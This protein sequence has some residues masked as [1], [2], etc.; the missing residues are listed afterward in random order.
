MWKWT[1]AAVWIATSNP[2]WTF[3][4]MDANFLPKIWAFMV[5]IQRHSCWRRLDLRKVGLGRVA[6]MLWEA[7]RCDPW[8]GLCNP[9]FPS[10]YSLSPGHRVSYP[11]LDIARVM[12]KE[13]SL[14]SPSFIQVFTMTSKGNATPFTNIQNWHFLINGNTL[15]HVVS[16]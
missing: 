4:S 3:S 16:T 10:S 14:T 8:Q 7:W 1:M 9:A 15:R 13:Q 5:H 2:I 6:H 12:R 11:L